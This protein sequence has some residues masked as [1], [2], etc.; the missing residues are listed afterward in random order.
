MFAGCLVTDGA[1]HGAEKLRREASERLQVLQLD[2]TSQNQLQAA[3]NTVKKTLPVGGEEEQ[4][5]FCHYFFLVRHSTKFYAL[6]E[7]RVEQYFELLVN[8]E[9]CLVT[10][11]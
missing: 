1:G 7:S 8:D 3:L 2:V 5:R 6:A 9:T 11:I 4:V 10:V